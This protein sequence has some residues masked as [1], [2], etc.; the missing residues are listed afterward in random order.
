[1]C[2]RDRFEAEAR[3]SRAGPRPSRRASRRTSSSPRRRG[4]KAPAKASQAHREPPTSSP[5]DEPA[6]EWVVTARTPDQRTRNARRGFD[7]PG[8]RLRL[9]TRGRGTPRRDREFGTADEKQERKNDGHNTRKT[10]FSR[11]QDIVCKLFRERFGCEK[12]L[13]L[14]LSARVPFA[15]RRPEARRRLLPPPLYDL[16]AA[17][18]TRGLAPRKPREDARARVERV[19]AREGHAPVGAVAR[20]RVGSVSAAD[21][22]PSRRAANRARHPVSYTHLTL[23]TIYSV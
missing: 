14:K 2:I 18:R 16:P 19:P 21:G 13:K 6:G 9:R 4:T 1:M 7:I 20:G 15:S 17:Q 11:V 22:K 12:A 23:P 10:P 5:R 8:T 3:T